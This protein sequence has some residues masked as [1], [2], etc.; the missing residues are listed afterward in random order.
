MSLPPTAGHETEQ[1]GRS[2]Q[3]FTSSL[4]A[5]GPVFRAGVETGAMDELIGCTSTATKALPD[6]VAT[7]GPFHAVALAGDALHRHRQ[8]LQQETGGHRGRATH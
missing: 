1:S 3:V 7:M 6:T 4:P 8:R 2:G 5:S